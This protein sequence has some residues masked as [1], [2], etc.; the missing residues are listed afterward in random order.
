MMLKEIVGY[1][2]FFSL[3]EEVKKLIEILYDKEVK[4][5]EELTNFVEKVIK[6]MSIVSINVK[7]K[8]NGDLITNRKSRSAVNKTI[9]E[10][11]SCLEKRQFTPEHYRDG[12]CC[13][14]RGFFYVK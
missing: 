13:D 3:V 11:F 8:R 1:K 5:F 6:D 12:W 9:G 14:T 7:S 10:L 2:D 4:L